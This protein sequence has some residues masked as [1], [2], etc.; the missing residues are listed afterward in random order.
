MAGASH[1]MTSL[2]TQYPSRRSFRASFGALTPAVLPGIHAKDARQVLSNALRAKKAG[3]RGMFMINHHFGPDELLPIMRTVRSELPD[4]WIGVNFLGWRAETC[5]QALSRL[6]SEGC[7]I[8]GLWMDDAGIHA[9][10][11]VSA[12]ASEF[13]RSRTSA[14]WKGLYF[15]GTA[16][17]YQTEI[18]P[19]NYAG[20]AQT[21]AAYTDV[22]TTSGPATGEAADPRK[23]KTFRSA[24]PDTPL[25]I[26]SGIS[27]ANI[28]QFGSTDAFLVAS[29]I[30]VPTDFFEIDDA[31]L[32]ELLAAA[33]TLL[34][35]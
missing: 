11:D 35:L 9:P 12:A 29:S 32:R 2:N 18:A 3:A 34:A 8:N 19:N 1:L 15:G 33:S 27:A 26:A 14:Q 13:Q 22:V 20:V 21:A 5:L 30:N 25:A 16:F 24:L 28:V 7:T 17:K 4:L 10:D 31:R 23:I 6:Q